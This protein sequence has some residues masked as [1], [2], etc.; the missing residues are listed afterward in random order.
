MRRLRLV[1]ILLVASTAL[2]ACKGNS[3]EAGAP[4][5]G[6]GGGGRQGGG[7]G[8]P[9]GR[10]GT[11]PAIPVKAGPVAVEQVTYAIKAVGT[12]EAEDLIQVPAQ[13]D[14]VLSAVNF[15]EGD[16]VTTKTVIASIDP[17]RYRLEYD[18][19]QANYERSVA[20]AANA[21]ATLARREALA[22]ENLVS[23]EDLNTTRTASLGMAA[24]TASL[25]AARDIAAQNLSRSFVKPPHGGIIDKRLVD[26]GTFVRTGTNL[27]TIVDLTRLQLRFKV[28]ETE[29]LRAKKDQLATFK[30]AATG[31]REF[32]ARIYH[33]GEVADA[34]S[35]QVQVLAWVANPGMLKPGFFA[36]ISLPSD[37]KKD[38]IVVPETAIQAS[39]RGFVAFVIED[40]KVK[41]RPVELGPRTGGGRVEILSGLNA[42]ETIVYEGSDRIAEGVS[43][44][45]EGHIPG[46]GTPTKAGGR[47]RRPGADA[48]KPGG[49]Q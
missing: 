5:G 39:D 20:S 24:D 29:S 18:R 8:R 14:G 27:A 3:P 35:R 47:N 2:T 31:D 37:S 33:V 36:E 15:R 41:V 12:L 43:V 21:S 32:T 1:A 30:V 28:S 25:K 40:G 23:A 17:E 16:R 46:E 7:G 4:G 26:T 19:A 38:A 34:A 45:T 11:A 22:K 13:L 10:G 48:A 44:T 6:Q 9:G 42:G 49:R